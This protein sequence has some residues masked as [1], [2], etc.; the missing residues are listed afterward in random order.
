MKVNLPENA[1]RND[2]PHA[3][4]MRWTRN[5]APIGSGFGNRYNAVQQEIEHQRI[6]AAF[7][8]LNEE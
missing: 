1:K 8:K 5:A 6:L 2:V 4:V 3:F 7:K